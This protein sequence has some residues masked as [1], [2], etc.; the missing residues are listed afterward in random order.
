MM[1]KVV[2]GKTH[3]RRVGGVWLASNSLDLR[4]QR[5]IVARLVER[6]SAR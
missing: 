4:A 2:S 1:R 3:L 6:L 5:W